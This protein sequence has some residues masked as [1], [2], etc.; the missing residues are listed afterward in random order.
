MPWGAA[1]NEAG[2]AAVHPFE[3]LEAAA[4]PRTDDLF[5]T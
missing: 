3:I 1:A 4:Q 2:G 5:K